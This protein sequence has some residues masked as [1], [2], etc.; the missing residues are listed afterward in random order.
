MSSSG[1]WT[2]WKTVTNLLKV[3]KQRKH[4]T[5]NSRYN[6]SDIQGRIKAALALKPGEGESSWAA[7]A[8]VLRN[9]LKR[10]HHR[11][12]TMYHGGKYYN[13]CGLI[14]CKIITI[15]YHRNSNIKIFHPTMISKTLKNKA[16]KVNRMEELCEGHI[17]P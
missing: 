16:D 10:Y 3:N 2:T 5:N 8:N 14:W 1:N 12:Q 7:T 4:N 15:T 6:V 11:Q 17:H 13:I 9:S